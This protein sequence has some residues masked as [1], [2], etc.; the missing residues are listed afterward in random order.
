MKYIKLLLL[1]CG[2]V[3]AVVLTLIM[4]R[5]SDV[6]SD[7]EYKNPTANEWKDKIKHLCEDGK[8]TQNGFV[9]IENGIKMDAKMNNLDSDEKS[10]LEQFLFASSCR[11]A[12]DG[13]DKL[14]KQ[15]SY[16]DQKT[17]HYENVVKF[18]KTRAGVYGSNSNLTEADNL[19]ASY[20]RMMGLLAF[21]SKATYTRPLKAFN[22][23]SAEEK[24]RT[25]KNMPHYKSHFSNNPSI[26]SK[27][28]CLEENM[29]KA[30]ADY[31]NNLASCVIDHHNKTQD[32]A[33]LLEDQMRFMEICTNASA[34]NR[35]NNFINNN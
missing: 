20:R 3:G 21:G 19:Y 23:G 27:V 13:S 8:W 7:P 5:P 31:Y 1:V 32:V 33:E 11:Y 6:I 34:T 4:M 10:S 12:K 28:E 9:T 18:L 26:R 30:E 17:V 35:L 24:R 14:F 15:S 25:I 29:R 16:P 2:I 22:S